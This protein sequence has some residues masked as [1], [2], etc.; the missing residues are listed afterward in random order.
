[1][2]LI[3]HCISAFALTDHL[4]FPVTFVLFFSSINDSIIFLMKKWGGGGGWGYNFG[5][6]L[7]HWFS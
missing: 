4:F 3:H 6:Q 7:V 5:I 1:M 2:L